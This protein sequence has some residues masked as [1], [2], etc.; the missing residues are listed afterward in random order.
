MRKPFGMRLVILFIWTWCLGAA[1]CCGQTNGVDR[2][3]SLTV[4]VHTRTYLLHVPE[5][6]PP[7]PRSV[8]VFHG[9]GGKAAGMRSI[10]AMNRVADRRGFVVAYPQG[11]GRVWNDG[12]SDLGQTPPRDD[13]AF[14]RELVKDVAGKVSI[15]RRRVFACGFSNGGSFTSRLTLEALD[16]IAAGA[17]V[18][19][20]LYA[21][22]RQTHPHPQPMPVLFIEGTDDPCHTYEGRESIGPRMCGIYKG[23]HHGVVLSTN[24]VISFWRNIDGCSDQPRIVK[25][26]HITWDRTSMP[27]KPSGDSLSMLNATSDD[28]K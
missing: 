26:P 15:N 5:S 20:G 13:V 28:T 10:T 19:S 7:T 21:K 12:G 27:V 22:Q 11:L 8:L 2:E 4:G 3:C 17:M 1:V 18:G 9:G 25:L 23:E 24:E 6:C 16:L 14:T